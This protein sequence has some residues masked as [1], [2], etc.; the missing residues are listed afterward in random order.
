MCRGRESAAKKMC[1]SERHF[2]EE[3]QRATRRLAA[4]WPRAMLR[5]AGAARPARVTPPTTR[6]LRAAAR[7]APLAAQRRPRLAPAATPQAPL[8]SAGG[9]L[10]S[11][12]EW[13]LDA[14]KEDIVWPE[15]L[16]AN[17][18]RAR[19]FRFWSAIGPVILRYQL[20][21][22]CLM[23]A[24]DVCCACAGALTRCALWLR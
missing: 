22:A 15:P 2:A 17:E 10:V 6:G 14:E 13:E 7:R 18:R 5:G 16:T 23:L 3:A 19:S 1:R 21:Q 8:S 9:D 12:R 4:T 20:L 24:R 11:W